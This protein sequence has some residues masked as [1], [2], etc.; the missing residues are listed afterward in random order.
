MKKDMENT[1]II[2]NP[3]ELVIIGSDVTALYPSLTDIEVAITCFDAVLNSDIKFLNINYQVAGKYVAMHLTPEE[4]RR[5]P[6]YNI[7]PELRKPASSTSVLAE[8]SGISQE[9][10]GPTNIISP[11]E[12]L[13]WDKYITNHVITLSFRFIMCFKLYSTLL[14][15]HFG[16]FNYSISQEHSEMIICLRNASSLFSTLPPVWV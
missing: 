9:H 16:V 11:P 4:Q 7:L 13:N 1:E 5:S 12:Y 14:K 2:Q 8:H 15:V 6:L 3:E 10:I